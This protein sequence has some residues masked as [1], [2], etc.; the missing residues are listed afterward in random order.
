MALHAL[1]QRHDLSDGQTMTYL[2]VKHAI[3][4]LMVKH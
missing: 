2:M 1:V 3:T 4:C